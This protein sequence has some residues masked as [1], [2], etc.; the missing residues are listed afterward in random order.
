MFMRLEMF[1]K[2]IRHIYATRDEELGCDELFEIVPRYVDMEI[3]GERTKPHFSEVEHHLSQCPHCYDLYLT[4]RDAALL[5]SRVEM[6]ESQHPE[7]ST[8]QEV[9]MF[10][11]LEVLEAEPLGGRGVGPLEGRVEML[12]SQH[13]EPSRDQEVEIFELLE[14]P[15]AEQ[16]GGQGVGP[17]KSQQATQRIDPESA[18]SQQS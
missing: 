11:L 7:P 10:E 9:E 14:V 1:R 8:D 12:E 6:L 17:L 15:E 4:L 2:W 3:A 13:P 16:L 5:E 18:V